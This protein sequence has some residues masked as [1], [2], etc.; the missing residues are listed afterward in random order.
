MT[1]LPAEQ[2]LTI[3]RG[4]AFDEIFEFKDE[5]GALIN[6]TGF[7][8]RMQARLTPASN[9]V[10]LDVSTANGKLTLGGALGTLSMTLSAAET[11]ALTFE[12]A[13]YDL[14]L[15]AAN[16]R[17]DRILKGTITLDTEVTR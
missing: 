1:Q 9:N 2:N 12:S 5:S 6:F 8:A 16:G 17:V 15:I 3:Y 11:A 10:L 14:E 13:S 4:S 7:S